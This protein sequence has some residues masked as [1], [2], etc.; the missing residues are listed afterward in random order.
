MKQKSLLDFINRK[1]RC[2]YCNKE[3][4]TEKGLKVHITKAH[5]FY[6]DEN[7]EVIEV[8]DN[9]IQLN[10]KMRKSLFNDLMRTV[11][12]SGTDLH[13]FLAEAFM[14]GDILFDEKVRKYGAEKLFLQKRAEPTYIT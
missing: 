5:F 11:E 2:K 3:F 6:H 13:H 14:V 8:D 4:L 12:R 9:H 1:Y 7:V 10:V